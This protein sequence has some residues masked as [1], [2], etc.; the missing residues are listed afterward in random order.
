MPCTVWVRFV[1]TYMLIC[2]ILL[3]C[4]HTVL[5]IYTSRSTD[6]SRA[7]VTVSMVCVT[8]TYIYMLHTHAQHMCLCI[9]NENRLF[10]GREPVSPAEEFLHLSD[11]T[12]ERSAQRTTAAH[13]LYNIICIILLAET[14]Y[15]IMRRTHDTHAPRPNPNALLSANSL[16]PSKTP[17]LGTFCP[18]LICAIL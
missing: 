15:Y 18:E 7:L 4:I 10:C 6:L 16:N 13:T 5:F 9:G 17:S 12:C 11:L 14:C 8:Y 1:G 2:Y 3:S